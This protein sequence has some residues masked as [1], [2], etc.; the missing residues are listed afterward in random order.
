MKDFYSHS[1]KTFETKII[2]TKS[3]D[4]LTT[5]YY[6]SI[7]MEE[8][9]LL[10]ALLILSGFFSGAEIALFT[11]GSERIHAIKKEATKKQ[12][13]RI[14][15]LE[16]LK[17]NPNRLLVTILIG[18][19]V[20]NV[21]A[22]AMAT[23]VA[24]ETAERVHAGGETGI[25][26]GAVTG[27][28]TFLILVFGEITPKALANKYALPFALFSTPILKFLEVLLSPIVYPLAK[29]VST[30]TK[31]EQVKHGL[32]EDELKAAI[33]LSA[34]EGEI[35]QEEKEL[36]ENVLGF[37]EHTVEEIMTPRSKMF[38]LNGDMSLKEALPII[39]EEKYSRIPIY[40]DT[41]NNI[42]GI[43][44]TRNL[45][46]LLIEK[47]FDL[48][49]KLFQLD[50]SNSLKVPPT[51]RIDSLMK[52]FQAQNT[53]HMALVYD[54][55][56][57]LIGLVTLEDILEEVVGE[58]HDET[59]DATFSIRKLKN[60]IFRCNSDTELKHIEQFL[61]QHLKLTEEDLPWKEED[62]NK[63]LNYFLLE[64]FQ[65]FPEEGESV[66]L[67]AH[68]HAFEFIIRSVKNHT[69]QYVDFTVEKHK[70]E[71]SK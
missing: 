33:H 61:Q 14:K 9:P 49:K 17:Q 12:K 19:N 20:V 63:T 43:L 39:I 70:K 8:V 10:V 54:E 27:V 11:L 53:S 28:M 32:S 23:V 15:Q 69:I 24:L 25:I 66:S 51:T 65:R 68:D 42:V 44:N 18:N 21:A 57:G 6:H 35:N 34:V 55:H 41:E 37:D 29:I 50:I 58:I 13:K 38:S 47:N 16:K 31:E 59:D 40:K 67:H 26:I 30:V 22:S 1:L 71:T 62:D 60:N 2:E 36:F 4:N 56:G 5:N 3:L 7:T 46:Q 48:E 45:I 64:E 52:Q